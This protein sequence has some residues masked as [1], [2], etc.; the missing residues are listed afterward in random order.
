MRARKWEAPMDDVHGPFPHPGP[1]LPCVMDDH[2]ACRKDGCICQCHKEGAT[3][4]TLRA[5]AAARLTAM[6]AGTHQGE[7]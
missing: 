5:D 3:S 6:Q 2:K 4:R 7:A 1:S